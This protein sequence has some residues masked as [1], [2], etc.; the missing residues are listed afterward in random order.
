M[1]GTVVSEEVVEGQ[2]INAN[3]TTPTIVQV[4]NLDIMT[5]VAEVAEADVMKLSEGMDV[6]F[7]TLGSGERK[8]HGVVRQIEPTP[9]EENDVVLY[10]VLVDVENQFKHMQPKFSCEFCCKG[11]RAALGGRSNR[12]ALCKSLSRQLHAVHDDRCIKIIIR[13]SCSNVGKLCR[14]RDKSTRVGLSWIERKASI[15]TGWCEVWSAI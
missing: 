2:T 3:Q 8:W 14:D 1:D 11:L 10:N 12:L 15:I 13:F 9:V 5:V 7:N 4:A 6:Y